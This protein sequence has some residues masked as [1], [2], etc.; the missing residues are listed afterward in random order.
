MFQEDKPIASLA[1]TEKKNSKTA[2]VWEWKG[3][4]RIKTG[5]EE[6][7]FSTFVVT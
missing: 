5:K 4:K 1:K 2:A 6:V 3:T 7:K